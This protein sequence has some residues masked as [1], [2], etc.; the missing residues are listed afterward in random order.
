MSNLC[1]Y[2]CLAVIEKLHKPFLE[3]KNRLINIL[4]DQ[5]P[6]VEMMQANPL[7]AAANASSRKKW[8]RVELQKQA[9][10]PSG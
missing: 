8:L 5:F 7:Y 3:L 9:G 6:P 4:F 10:L 2:P 1:E